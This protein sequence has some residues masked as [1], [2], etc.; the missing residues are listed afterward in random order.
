MNMILVTIVILLVLGVIIGNILLLRRS[1]KF[2][3]KPGTKS[4][5]Y[6]DDDDDW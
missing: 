4:Q 2:Q 6:K 5:P 3:T 1:T